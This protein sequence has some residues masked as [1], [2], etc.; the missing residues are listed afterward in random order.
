[1]SGPLRLLVVEDDFRV[2][3]LHAELAGTV[4]GVEV[5]GV[6]HTAADALALA[7]S[8]HPDL[9]LLDEYLPDERGTSLIRRLD[10]AVM[11]VSAENDVAVIRRAVAAGA[12]NVILKP[13]APPVLTQRLAAF[14]RFWTALESGQADQRAVDRALATLREG[15]SPAGAMPK[16]RSAVTADAVRD[17]LRAAAD[18]LTAQE[19]ADA[20]GVSRA[21][22]QRYLADLVSAG[23]VE[24]GLRYGSTGRP[25]HRYTWRR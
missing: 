14:R 25:E 8:E 24:L 16:G 5:V 10:A 6:A 3:R 21:T 11:L 17:A 22:A 1:M 7:A 20:T 4:E 12:V 15:D 13:F 19:V 2:A 9:V 23:R 18:A